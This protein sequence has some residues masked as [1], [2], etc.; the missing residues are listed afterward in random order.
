MLINPI[1]IGKLRYQGKIY[2]AELTEFINFWTIRYLEKG[3]IICF[4]SRFECRKTENMPELFFKRRFN[5]SSESVVR[6]Q[7]SA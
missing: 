4:K 5:S 2:D 1:Y 7:Y 3:E 6:K